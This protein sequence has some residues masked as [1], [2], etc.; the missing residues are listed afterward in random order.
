LLIA[1]IVRVQ[2]RIKIIQ[3][4]GLLG[5]GAGYLLQPPIESLLSC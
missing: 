1:F 4:S 3:M 2:K 5:S